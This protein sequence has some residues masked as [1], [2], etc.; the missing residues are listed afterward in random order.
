MLTL[1]YI[2]CKNK[3]EAQKIS[4]T[5]VKEKLI[6]CANIVKSQS[7]FNWEG[8]LENGD[9]WIILAKT[10]P[11]KFKELEPIVK[12]LHSY[13]IPCILGIPV[14]ENSEYLDWAKEQL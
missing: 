1:A 13:E 7:I 4:E 5:L 11:E 10:M 3:A 14:D 8:K 12:E 9:E 2:P 6:A